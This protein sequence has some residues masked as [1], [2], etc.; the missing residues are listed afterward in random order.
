[1]GGLDAVSLAESQEGQLT[2]G[3]FDMLLSHHAGGRGPQGQ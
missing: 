3:H 1:M 2:S